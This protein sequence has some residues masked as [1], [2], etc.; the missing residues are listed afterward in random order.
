MIDLELNGKKHPIHFGWLE[1]ETISESIGNK[2]PEETANNMPT[3]A[4][5]MKFNRV[6]LFE[7]L[8]GGYRKIGEVC[9]FQTADEIAE[10]VESFTQVMPALE[11]YI[12]RQAEFFAVEDS[13]PTKKKQAASH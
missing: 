12:K 10:V 9:P 13:K 7:G 3:L 4:S 11:Y 8:K 2:S 1:L 5:S 6:V